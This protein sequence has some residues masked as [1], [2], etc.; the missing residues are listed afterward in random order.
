LAEIEM[1]KM[2]ITLG[3]ELFQ[4]SSF[5]NWCDKASSKFAKTGRRGEQVLCLDTF[6]RV[7]RTGREFM[8]ARDEG[9]FPVRV[10]DQCF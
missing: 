3:K 10:F 2:S 4:F 6:G 9:A 5:D 7:C 1:H 8:R